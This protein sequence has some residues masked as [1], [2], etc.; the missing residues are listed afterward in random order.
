MFAGF[1]SFTGVKRGREVPSPTCPDALLPQQYRAPTPSAQVCAPPALIVA[2]PA[3]VD[4][5]SVV[6]GVFGELLFEDF[7]HALPDGRSVIQIR[8]TRQGSEGVVS[9]I[10]WNY[11]HT[12]IP[13]HLRD[14]VITE[15]G[16][17]DLR[18]QTDEEVIKLLLSITDS[19]FQEGLAQ[20][21]KTAGKLSLDYEVPPQFRKNSP[22]AH[23]PRLAKLR[24]QGLFPPFP[25]GTDFTDIEIAL[26]NA[27]KS[28]KRK[29]SSPGGLIGAAAVAFMAKGVEENFR[30][31]LERMGLWDPKGF[32]EKLYASLIAA[33]LAS[34]S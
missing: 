32:K 28:L 23:A 4:D 30:P 17:V 33:E 11:G 27:L 18:G 7:Q 5:V 34:Q 15:Y 6:C 8:S 20:T 21:A 26:G 9:N 2:V 12:T 3:V 13:R 31:H 24:Q 10:V 25:F 16:M 1:G 22:A 14:L 19:R 29:T